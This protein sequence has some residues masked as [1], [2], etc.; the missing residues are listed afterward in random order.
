MDI[1]ISRDSELMV[2]QAEGLT[3]A[4]T[5]FVDAWLGN[6]PEQMTVVDEGRIVL[7]QAGLDE[8]AAAA[9]GRGLEVGRVT[10]R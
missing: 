10:L 7:P 3:P 9:A 5:E 8:L 1:K 6:A 2:G 4:G